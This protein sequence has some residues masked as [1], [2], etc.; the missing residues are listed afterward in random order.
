[1]KLALLMAMSGVLIGSGF[2][3]ASEKKTLSP[4]MKELIWLATSE[5]CGKVL[6]DQR[7]DLVIV[8]ARLLQDQEAMLRISEDQEQLNSYLKGQTGMCG[9][10]P[11][12]T[13]YE[14]ESYTPITP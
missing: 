6:E 12:Q 11:K 14:L 1:M 2:S 4:E 3:E 8:T 5:P 9:M 13:F 10:F 7:V